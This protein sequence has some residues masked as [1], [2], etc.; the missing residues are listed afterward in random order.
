M[1][2]L[3][4]LDE[5]LSALDAEARDRILARL[6]SWLGEHAIQTILVTHDA[7]DALATQA[8]VA[9]LREGRLTALGPAVEVLAAERKRLQER[10]GSA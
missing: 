3:L 7:A 10:L 8:E 6:Q 2:R 9:V 5:P 1:P 4:L